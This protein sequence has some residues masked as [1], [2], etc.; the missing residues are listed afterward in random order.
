MELTR[1]LPRLP[2]RRLLTATGGLACGKTYYYKIKA[3]GTGSK[4]KISGYSKV[5]SGKP[6]PAKPSVTLASGK[7]K[8]VKVSWKKISGASGYEIYYS[9]KKDGSYKKAKTITSGKTVTYTQKKLKSGKKYYYSVRAYRTVN[10]KK[11]YGSYSAVKSVK[12]K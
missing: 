1:R 6:V 12:V 7:S 3:V 8:Q 10:G 5:V 4:E 11:V 9:T 2:E